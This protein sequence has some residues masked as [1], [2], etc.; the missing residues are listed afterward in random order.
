MQHPW[1]GLRGTLVV[2]TGLDAPP[3]EIEGVVADVSPGSQMV[4]PC[5]Y[6]LPL[7]G[8]KVVFSGLQ[9]FTPSDPAEARR[10]LEEGR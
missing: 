5:I 8:G 10:R 9:D 7:G 3:R 4:G 2:F 6:L 1:I